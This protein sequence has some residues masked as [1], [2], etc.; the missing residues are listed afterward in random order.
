MHQVPK[1]ATIVE[2]TNNKLTIA[3]MMTAFLL[4]NAKTMQIE[5]VVI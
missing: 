1:M 4:A 3:F 5:S 2:K